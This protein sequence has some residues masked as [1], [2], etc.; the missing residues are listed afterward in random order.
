MANWLIMRGKEQE[1][2]CRT[3][4]EHLR[5]HIEVSPRNLFNPPLGRLKEQIDKHFRGISSNKFMLRNI[6]EWISS[7]NYQRGVRWG[8]CKRPPAVPPV[9]LFGCTQKC[10]YFCC[11]SVAYKQCAGFCVLSL[12]VLIM[13]SF[14]L[15]SLALMLNAL[16]NQ[17]YRDFLDSKG[18]TN[19]IN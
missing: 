11:L 1:V 10:A 9:P 3:L 2:G 15:G 16:V 17:F 14:Q 12:A 8:L 4:A 6:P 19:V 13:S 7:Y 18:P 5:D